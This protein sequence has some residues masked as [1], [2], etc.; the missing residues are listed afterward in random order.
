MERMEDGSRSA[1]GCGIEEEEAIDDTERGESAGLLA[2]DASRDKG[3]TGDETW[4]GGVVAD[5]VGGR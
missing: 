2:C 3:S 4:T 1:V 5:G